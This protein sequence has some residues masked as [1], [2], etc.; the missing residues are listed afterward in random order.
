MLQPMTHP[1]ASAHGV[2]QEGVPGLAALASSQP[3]QLGRRFEPLTRKSPRLNQKVI[4][5]HAGQ[6]ITTSAGHHSSAPLLPALWRCQTFRF[7]TDPMNWFQIK[8]SN[9][10]RPP[11]TGHFSCFR[12]QMAVHQ[13]RHPDLHRVLRHPPGDGGPHFPHPVHGAGQAGDFGALGEA[14][15]RVT[16]R[17]K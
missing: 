5:G 8:R 10:E 11:S 3:A 9:T 13:P 6:V 12:S 7:L 2:T 14:A 16:K 17:Q 4:A 15:E 1:L